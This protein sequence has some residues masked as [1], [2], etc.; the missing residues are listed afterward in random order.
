[1]KYHIAIFLALAFALSGVSGAY[2]CTS[3][4]ACGRA[5]ADGRPL[6]WKHRDTGARD[7]FLY[8]V[9]VPGRIG[10]VGLFNGGDTLVL[11]E[12]WMGMNDAGFAIMN[13]V[14]YNLAEND[15]AWTDREGFVM[16]EAL[17]RCVTVD[18]F[19][20]LLDSLPKPMGLRTNFGCIDAAGGAAYF[21]TDDTHWQRYNVDDNEYGVLVR[22]N[23]SESGT[24][25]TGRGYDRYNNVYDILSEAIVTGSLTAASLT[26]GVSRS[27][28]DAEHECD[29]LDGDESYVADE[30]FVPRPSSTASIVVEGLLSG[31]EPDKM[32][33]WTVLGY[34]P[35]SPVYPAMLHVI[36]AVLMPGNEGAHAPANEA[37]LEHMPHIFPADRGTEP[38]YIDAGY[39][40]PLIEKARGESLENYSQGAAAR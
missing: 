37:A 39:L 20:A 33:M 19:E 16:A 29:M 30:H 27:F 23:F 13:T 22:T 40:R 4:I 2:A 5:T 38:R 9:D 1:M 25:G 34:P 6:L 24:D 28:Y 32:I 10:Y 35:V 31:E 3:L 8:R 26:E 14:A 15:P 7:N 36:P 12:A 18:D 17:G 21:E 11:D